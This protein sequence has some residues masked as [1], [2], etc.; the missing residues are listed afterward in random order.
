[1][2]FQL[3]L[4]SISY[5]P[6][7]IL[8][9]TNFNRFLILGLNLNICSK[10]VRTNFCGGCLCPFMMA[11]IVFPREDRVTARP[12]ELALELLSTGPRSRRWSRPQQPGMKLME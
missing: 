12:E 6:I 8:F 9:P 7:S 10:C 5:I 3:N 4:V 1:M 2:S 11:R